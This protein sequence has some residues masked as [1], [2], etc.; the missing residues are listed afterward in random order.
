MS[1]GILCSTIYKFVCDFFS[2]MF[3]CNL[4]AFDQVRWKDIYGWFLESLVEDSSSTQ[5]HYSV[6]GS[7]INIRHSES[8]LEGGDHDEDRDMNLFKKWYLAN[9]PVINRD[10]QLNALMPVLK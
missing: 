4:N 8:E 6:A 10:V 1:E 9:L 7:T 5:Q 2:R 3:M